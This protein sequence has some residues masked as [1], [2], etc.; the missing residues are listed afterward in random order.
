MVT[1]RAGFVL[2]GT[3]G[4]AASTLYDG[5]FAGLYVGD[6][7]EWDA[8]THDAWSGDDDEAQGGMKREEAVVVF[9]TGVVVH[10]TDEQYNALERGG[11]VDAL[12]VVR[13][14]TVG[15]AV[16][17]I[18]PAAPDVRDVYASQNEQWK[19]KLRLKPLGKL[20]C[21]CWDA[22]TCLEYDVPPPPPALR[23][24]E[25]WVDDDVLAVCFVGMKFDAR[26]LHLTTGL[27]VLDSVVNTY[28]SFYQ[29]LPNELLIESRDKEIRF[30]KPKD[31]ELAD[32]KEE[33]DQGN[34]DETALVLQSGKAQA[35]AP[36]QCDLPDLEVAN[37]QTA[38]CSIITPESAVNQDQ[39]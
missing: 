16:V 39:D 36:A 20:L 12:H 30:L 38:S 15:L 1:Q 17:A 21:T 27:V 32:L 28:C 26:V 18:Q 35:K 34:D 24:Y 22:P 33:E 14:E 31:A 23:D 19:H 4:V 9:K 25:F 8:S 11:G 13:R 2:P 10:G 37:G 29:W 6:D 5:Y 3:F 7:A